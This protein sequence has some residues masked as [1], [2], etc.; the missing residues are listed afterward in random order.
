MKD[1][2]LVGDAVAGWDNLARITAYGYPDSAAGKV[3]E[4]AEFGMDPGLILRSLATSVRTGAHLPDATVEQRACINICTEVCQRL[5]P[6]GCTKLG[7]Y[8]N[9]IR[10]VLHEN[11][12]GGTILDFGC[13]AWVDA[14][15]SLAMGGDYH[16][17]MMDVLEMPLSFAAFQLGAR[18][19][20]HSVTLVLDEA[21]QLDLVADDVVMIVESS[22]FEHVPHLREKFEPLMRKL[23]AGGLFLTNYTRLDWTREC[24]DGHQENK[25]FAARAVEIASDL[26]YRYEWDPEQGRGDGWDLWEMKQ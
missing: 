15:M 23:P 9:A 19:I 24:L 8:I 2:V 18:G 17:Q 3:S 21:T 5:K 20:R 22:S 26:A 4:L 13:G 12:Y 14:S 6:D 7:L 10:D 25:D 11:F 1:R 16:V